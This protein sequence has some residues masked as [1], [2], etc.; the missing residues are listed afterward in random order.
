MSTETKPVDV[1]ALRKV[2]NAMGEHERPREW[3]YRTGCNG[4]PQ[5][6]Y[7]EG[8]VCEIAVATNAPERPIA[9]NY[10][11]TFDPPTVLAML[12]EIEQLRALANGRLA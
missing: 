9:A 1:A 11:T 2:V 6:V 4:Y 5:T 10:I 3:H 8:D 7:S 12:D